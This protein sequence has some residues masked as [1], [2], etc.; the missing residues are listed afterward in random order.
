MNVDFNFIELALKHSLGAQTRFRAFEFQTF[1]IIVYYVSQ[2]LG[3]WRDTTFTLFT[4]SIFD[5]FI[6]VILLLNIQLC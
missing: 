6:S 4:K 5:Y 1:E 3:S 2:K